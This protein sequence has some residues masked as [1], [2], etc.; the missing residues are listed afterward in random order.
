M[1]CPSGCGHWQ[2]VYH[3]FR[4]FQRAGVWPLVRAKPMAFAGAAGL[5]AWSV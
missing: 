1:T 3:L 5:V 2:S 4:R